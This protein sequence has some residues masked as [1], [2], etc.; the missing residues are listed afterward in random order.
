MRIITL[1]GIVAQPFA[2]M[3]AGMLQNSFVLTINGYM[4][5]TAHY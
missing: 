4:I 1:A 3:I 5:K 2:Y